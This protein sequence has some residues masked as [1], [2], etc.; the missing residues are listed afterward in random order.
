M[1][2]NWHVAATVAVLIWSAGKGHPLLLHD[3]ERL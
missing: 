1:T 2:L 3:S